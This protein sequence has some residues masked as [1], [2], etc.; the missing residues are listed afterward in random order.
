MSEIPG[1]DCRLSASGENRLS[2]DF[3]GLLRMERR[4]EGSRE[5]GQS[6]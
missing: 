2:D 3:S 5:I 1:V 4:V 6:I